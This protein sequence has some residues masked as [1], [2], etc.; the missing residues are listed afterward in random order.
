MVIPAFFRSRNFVSS[1][2]HPP[3][4]I[5]KLMVV[6]I[7]F[8]TGAPSLQQA[9]FAFQCVKNRKVGALTSRKKRVPSKKMSIVPKKLGGTTVARV[10]ASPFCRSFSVSSESLF[11]QDH[12]LSIIRKVVDQVSKSLHVSQS[13]LVNQCD[14]Q[15][16]KEQTTKVRF[17]VC[18]CL[19]MFCFE[20]KSSLKTFC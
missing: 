17:F 1:F 4:S 16:H 13:T 5:L 11:L 20:N 9:H 18:W 15:V 3:V 7:I 6:E 8:A 2:Q 10:C 14:H 19:G 12:Q